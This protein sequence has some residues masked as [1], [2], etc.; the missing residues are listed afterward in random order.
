[1]D[2]A[3]HAAAERQPGGLAGGAIGCRALRPDRGVSVSQTKSR[4]RAASDCGPHQP[5]PGD[6]TADHVVEPAGLAGD[7][8]H[9]ARD[10]HRR[11]AALRATALSESVGWQDSRAEARD[12]GLP[13]PDRD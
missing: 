5:G 9:A 11:V 3:V 10:S 12:R 6:L 4:V 7:S 2:A 8:R 13:E 1:P